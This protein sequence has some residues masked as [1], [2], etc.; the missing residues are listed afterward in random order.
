MASHRSARPLSDVWAPGICRWFRG[1]TLP[2]VTAHLCAVALLLNLFAPILWAVAA[3]PAGVDAPIL[4]HDVGS[5]DGATQPGDPAKPSA[6]H[7]P[8]CPLCVLFGGTAWAPPATGLAMV[9]AAP[10]RS[11][12]IAVRG[13]TPSAPLP[14]T[15]RPSPRGPPASI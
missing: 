6:D 5:A 1:R 2:R 11:T 3:P 4:C 13:E 7:V 10:R 8:H 15:L 9:A 12:T 14:N